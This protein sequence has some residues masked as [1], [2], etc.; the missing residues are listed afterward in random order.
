MLL[1]IGYGNPLRNDDGVGQQVAQAFAAR[2]GPRE[3]V[4]ILALHQLTPE[5]AEPIS[6]AHKVIFVDAS[7]DS[8][9]GA[10]TYHPVTPTPAQDGS[11]FTHNTSPTGLLAGARDLYGSCPEGLLITIGGASFELGETLSEPVQKALPEVLKALLAMLP[12]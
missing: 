1:V 2:S 5:L 9:P 3:D 10:I 8:T 6:R 4:E 11:A 12:A 7:A